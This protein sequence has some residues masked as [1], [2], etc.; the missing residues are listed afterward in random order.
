MQLC[1]DRA[2]VPFAQNSYTVDVHRTQYGD[3][4]HKPF[5][6]VYDIADNRHIPIASS[7]LVVG[8][9]VLFRVKL[10]RSSI[11]VPE[12]SLTVPVVSAWF[13]IEV[14]YRL[15]AYPVG[16]PATNSNV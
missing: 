12:V 7:D 10:R 13:E 4:S 8:D 15:C 1:M 16:D 11:V 2:G 14:I 3:N 9:L 6:S 5:R